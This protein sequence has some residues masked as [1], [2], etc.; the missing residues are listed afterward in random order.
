MRRHLAIGLAAILGLALGGAG[1]EPRPTLPLVF[2]HRGD[3]SVAPENTVAAIHAATTWADGVEFDV[4]LA[5]DGTWRLAH[6]ELPRT[7]R[8]LPT[9]SEAVAAAGNLLL[10]IDLKESSDDAHR[11]LGEWIAAAGIAERTTVN[12]KSL[13]GARIIDAIV[14][15]VAIE[16]QPEWVPEAATAREIDR[17]AVW[18][19][20]WLAILEVRPASEVT[21][22]VSSIHEPGITRWAEAVHERIGRYMADGPPDEGIGA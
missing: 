16:A 21:L 3:T 19:A 22:F 20:D 5:L 2:A 15:G 8:S 6:D 4:H 18:G 1:G 7:W 12:V 13:S 10:E 17:V 9:I 14:P 11:R